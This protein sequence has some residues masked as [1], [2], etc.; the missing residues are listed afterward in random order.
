MCEPWPT[1][2]TERCTGVRIP[3][4]HVCAAHA[5][6]GTLQHWL[7]LLRSGAPLDLR[8]V[9]FDDDLLRAALTAMRST[10]PDQSLRGA[11]LKL[12]G[13]TAADVVRLDRDTLGGK[14]LSLSAH[15]VLLVEGLALQDVFVQQFALTK[16]HSASAR[17]S[18]QRCGLHCPLE[19]DVLDCLGLLLRDCVIT[20]DV[21]ARSARFGYLDLSGT[22]IHR[23]VLDVSR[24]LV[25]KAAF[26]D[27]TIDGTLVL[28][29]SVIEDGADSRVIA[30]EVIGHQPDTWGSWLHVEAPGTVDPGL[31][32]SYRTPWRP[33]LFP[34]AGDPGRLRWLTVEEWV[35]DD[36]R[37]GSDGALHKSGGVVSLRACGWPLV[38]E[39]GRLVV[40][41]AE[42]EI[43]AQADAV[44]VVLG[45]VQLGSVFAVTASERM[46][47]RQQ[48]AA[49]EEIKHL[50]GPPPWSDWQDDDE[51]LSEALTADELRALFDDVPLNITGEADEAAAAAMLAALAPVVFPG[52][53][54][55]DQLLPEELR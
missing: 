4:T 25:G 29:G 54:L 12:D 8:G 20:G 34:L 31:G 18:I 50:D 51:A 15:G 13:A 52:D 2:A 23:G 39:S 36:F 19:L 24:S 55:A 30:S 7:R 28:Y 22:R 1:C 47:A 14:P 41:E 16:A 11:V 40:P 35:G 43:V 33:E 10:P 49:E 3:D 21:N 9:T 46:L 26:H 27:V 6:E 38:E 53:P 5:D 42:L 48:A 37:S 32:Q 17:I 44:E 45:G